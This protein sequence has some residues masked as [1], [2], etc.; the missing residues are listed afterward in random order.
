VLL[1]GRTVSQAIWGVP[2]AVITTVERWTT[3]CVP[4]YTVRLPAGGIGDW[5]VPHRW[6]W[7]VTG[8]SGWRYAVESG[9]GACRQHQTGSTT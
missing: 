6:A 5:L 9:A 1:S 7:A 3:R 8:W 2:G 4:H